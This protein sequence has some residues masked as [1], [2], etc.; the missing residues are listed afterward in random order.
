M[1]HF[2]LKFQPSRFEFAALIGCG[3][4]TGF[5]AVFEAGDVSAGDTVAVFGCGGIGLNVV[6]S[7]RLA[8]AVRVIAVD[9]VPKKLEYAKQMGA[10]DVIDSSESNA[11]EA[12]HDLTGN[13]GVDYAFEAVGLPEP[14]EQAYDSTKKGGTCIVVGM[15]VEAEPSIFHGG[16]NL[17]HG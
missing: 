6:Q 4:I 5:G 11:V 13:R 2:F 8:G 9:T 17:G 3:V 14:I 12:I 1:G 16:V 15:D 7:A 10:T